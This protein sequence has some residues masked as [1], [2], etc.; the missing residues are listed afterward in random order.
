MIQFKNLFCGRSPYLLRQA[1]FYLFSRPKL[2]WTL[3]IRWRMFGRNP[4]NDVWV[5]PGDKNQRSSFLRRRAHKNV[6]LY[7]GGM[8]IFDLIIQFDIPS[9]SC[10]WLVT[11]TTTTKKNQRQLTWR[12]PDVRRPKA[13]IVEST[14]EVVPRG[15]QKTG[16]LTPGAICCRVWPCF[17]ARHTRDTGG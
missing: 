8:K 6:L 2:T 13:K 15:W 1:V 4:K 16:T 3:K 7:K 11:D 9:L 14:L 17:V 5:E 12:S 10:K